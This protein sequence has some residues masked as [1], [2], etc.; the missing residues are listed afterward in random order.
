MPL[1]LV[2]D[3]K[4]SWAMLIVMYN[5]NWQSVKTQQILG[6][7]LHTYNSIGNASLYS[8]TRI[9]L[10]HHTTFLHK[11]IQHCRFYWC[12][13]VLAE[14]MGASINIKKSSCDNTGSLPLLGTSVIL[15]PANIS[16]VITQHQTSQVKFKKQKWVRNEEDAIHRECLMTIITLSDA[17]NKNTSNLPPPR[18]GCTF[19]V[20]GT[21]V[22]VQ[23]VQQPQASDQIP[24][25]RNRTLSNEERKNTTAVP[26]T[27][28][29]II[30]VWCIKH[31]KK[32]LKTAHTHE[33]T[34]TLSHTH[35]R[36]TR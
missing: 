13:A 9:F 15:V 4:N 34:C 17:R 7:E 30:S 10:H 6:S 2:F 29:L 18:G 16:E 32:I 35:P 22:S 8:Q 20:S 21:S 25:W 26:V 1:R 11:G 33:H 28:K 3:K 23:T 36:G 24:E 31:E 19:R 27:V 5:K 12:S 14:C